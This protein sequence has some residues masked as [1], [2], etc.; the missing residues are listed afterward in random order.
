VCR[1]EVPLTVARHIG[2]FAPT[3]R[4]RYPN[5]ESELRRQLHSVANR[6]PAAAKSALN[7]RTPVLTELDWRGIDGEA[8]A[9]APSRASSMTDLHEDLRRRLESQGLAV[10]RFVRYVY[11]IEDE[12]GQLLMVQKIA[13]LGG[14]VSKAYLGW[15]LL[16]ECYWGADLGQKDVTKSA[17]ASI[18]ALTQLAPKASELALAN[19]FSS[20][21][22]GEQVLNVVFYW[23]TSDVSD[24][25]L[26]QEWDDECRWVHKDQIESQL[27]LADDRRIVASL[28]KA[29]P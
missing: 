26:W 8:A 24:F 19:V 9:S 23:R 28:A 29:Q 12:A 10:T 17:I 6:P 14:V 13:Q 20:N 18:S 2:R 3:K 5:A 21:A 25:D 4:C 22:Q 7:E 1:G 15:Q 11:V 27:P 16:S